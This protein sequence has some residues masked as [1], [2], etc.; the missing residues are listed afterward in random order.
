MMAKRFLRWLGICY[1][2]LFMAIAVEAAVQERGGVFFERDFAPAQSIVTDVERPFRDAICLN[3]R[4]DFQP[5]KLPAGWQEGQGEAPE[6]PMPAENGWDAVKIKVPSPWNVNAL[7]HDRSG[8]GMDSRTFPSYPQ[9]WNQ[10]KMGWLR[11]Q[12]RFPSDWRGRRI[13]LHLEA[14]SGE[15]AV[16]MNGRRMGVHFDN[17][18]PGVLDITAAVECGKDNTIL[19]GIRGGELFREKGTYGS[20]TYPTGSFWLTEAIGVWQDVY[21]IATPEVHVTNVFVIPK[22]SGNELVVDVKVTNDGPRMRSV[23]VQVPVCPWI[24]GTDLSA[25]NVL[26]APEIAWSLGDK[27][28][29]LSSEAMELSA[30]ASHTFHLKTAVDDRLKLWTIWTLGKPNLYAALTEVVEDGKSI[31]RQYARFGWRE[32]ELRDGDLLLNGQPTRMMHDFWHFMGVQAMSRRYVWAWYTLAQQ[33]HVTLIRPHAMPH[34]QYYYDLADEMGML[35]MDE[36][37]IFASHCDLNYDS[38]VFWQRSQEHIRNLVRR[39]RNHPSVVGWSVSNEV[40]CV[41]RSRAS[42]EYQEKIYDKIDDLCKI[43]AELDPTRQWI[44]SDGDRDLNGRLNVY[45]IHCGRDYDQAGPAGKLWGVTEGGSAYFGPTSYYEPFVGDRAY[46]SFTDRMDALGIECYAL[47]RKLRENDADICNTVNLFW[48][49]IKPMPLGLKDL[50]KK[51]LDLS[52][53]VFFSPYRED[54]PGIQPERIAPF[55]TTV[56][57]GYDA[58]LPLFEPWPL[59]SAMLAAFDPRGPQPCP[60]DQRTE[61]KPSVPTA[62]ENPVHEVAFVGDAESTLFDTLRQM[63]IPFAATVDS[64][65]FVIVDLASLKTDHVDN[66]KQIFQRCVDNGGTVLLVNGSPQTQGKAAALIGAGID[67]VPDEKASLVPGK[68]NAVTA[69]ITYKDLYFAE[70]YVSKVI[71]R[72]SLAGEFVE[73]GEAALATNNTDWRRWLN[74]PEYSKT[75]SIYRS[76]L[77]NKQSPVVVICSSG[78]GRYVVSTLITEN[79]SDAHV[80]LYRKLLANLGV[81]LNPTTDLTIPAFTGQILIRALSC[82]RFGAESLNTAMDN[83][84]VG[85]RTI[86]PKRG[87]QSAAL[88]W[89]MVDNTGDRFVL[90][91][92]GQKGPEDIYVTYF[93]FWVYSPIALNDLLGAGPDLPEVNLFC[94]V[95][96]RCRVYL[97]HEVLSPNQS[98]PADYRVQ[99]M[100]QKIPLQKGWNHFLI[101]VASDSYNQTNP[102]TLAVRLT[103]NKPEYINQI[104]TALELN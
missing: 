27:V 99:E 10:V 3:G 101:K 11:R 88:E 5:V 21:L 89:N 66:A 41:L 13:F 22:V 52:E 65:R 104:K 95:S 35:V 8:G 86:Q 103:S 78:T 1:A 62:V 9:R 51:Q 85:E 57:P 23:Q 15:C 19:L 90:N 70:N 2:G 37:G 24:N 14:V 59:Y 100:Y 44:Q 97:N 31:D 71:S 26:K 76:E 61:S 32:L 45:T 30:G 92:L 18:L 63:G 7:L 91:Q 53:G 25:G 83:D 34:P 67:Y 42:S 12:I 17:A 56:N 75:I 58:S 49:G 36:S 47:L 28:L 64:A 82:G 80:A 60:W 16:F 40:W 77:E 84:F 55:S 87:E 102:G 96:D 54:K 29:Q 93:S 98:N 73:R 4:W 81:G 50:S 39:D 46:R 79:L 69:G 68:A 74:G 72:Y 38:S 43:A 94:Y 48:H 33:A 20:F 6:L